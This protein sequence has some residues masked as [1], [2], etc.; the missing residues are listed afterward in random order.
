MRINYLPVGVLVLSLCACASTTPQNGTLSGVDVPGE[1][2]ESPKSS[3]SDVT[4]LVNWWN[5]FDDP[6]LSTLITRALVNNTTVKGTQ[7]ALQQARALRDVT[8][9]G[10]LPSLGSSASVQ[11]SRNGDVSG[12]SFRGGLDANW[13]LDV[14][15]ANRSAVNAADATALASAASLGDVQ[16]SIA[17]EVALNYI[18]LRS[19]Q[20]R[21]SIASDNLTSQS[22]TLQITQWRLQAGLVSS[23]EDEQARA[24]T[25]QTRAQLPALQTTI[26]QTR[27]A[28]AVLTGQA[29]AALSAL[30]T[31][32][33]PVP[34]ASAELALSVP[35]EVLRQRSDVRA[36]EY[37]VQ[38]AVAR[39]A[40]ADAA[41]AP[42]FKLGGSLGLNALTLGALTDGASLA[43]AVLAGVTWPVFDGGA[44]RA[45]VRGQQAALAQAN[46]AYQ[47]TVLTAL[48][49]VE[50]ALVV[51]RGD[52]A[53][54][55]LLQSAA[56]SANAAAQL[57]SQRYGSGLVDFQ[58]VLETQR[59]RL[60]SQDSVAVTLAAVSA[61]HVRLYKA[62]G[63]GW[64][65]DSSAAMPLPRQ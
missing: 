65:Q 11:R 39:V 32:A 26:A 8:A 5:Y 24:A 63:G 19:A 34:Q 23:L 3:A 21:L 2:S 36:A 61:D 57:A 10:L 20:A 12:N 13:E 51:L 28:L 37:Q 6:L 53:R 35:A 25:D 46:S 42:S 27:H 33:G 58:T 56:A 38:A 47:A 29:P 9:A 4:S 17:A 62:L 52:R 45:Q 31:A 7:A 50:D 49:D 14:F 43:A 44:A 30:L 64:Q 40:Q 48:T 60:G 15:G 1:W 54:L 41:R 18:A 59:I 55:A 16:V 22:E